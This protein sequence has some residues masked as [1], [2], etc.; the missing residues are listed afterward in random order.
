MIKLYYRII[1]HSYTVFEIGHQM[2]VFLTFFKEVFA[3]KMRNFFFHYHQ[4]QRRTQL[5]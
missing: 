1:L 2:H 3:C 4:L 5:E